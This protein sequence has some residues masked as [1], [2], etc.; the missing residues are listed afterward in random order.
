MYMYYF[1]FKEKVFSSNSIADSLVRS[2]I[3][4]VLMFPFHVM[5]ERYSLHALLYVLLP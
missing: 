1:G 5:I 4:Y 3:E 2:V